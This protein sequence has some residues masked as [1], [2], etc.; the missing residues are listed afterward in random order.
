MSAVSRIYAAQAGVLPRDEKV[1]RLTNW[2]NLEKVLLAG[3]FIFSLGVCCCLYSVLSWQRFSD[4]GAFDPRIG[5]RILI[6]A[7]TLIMTGV[8]IIFTSF[9]LE[10][11][12]IKNKEN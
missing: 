1:L 4:F 5:F 10:L 6:P 8:Q 3:A 11:L 12:S 2:F 7:V 9:M